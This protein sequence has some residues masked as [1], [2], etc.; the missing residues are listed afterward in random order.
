M[1][2]RQGD[3][4]TV[5]SKA[6]EAGGKVLEKY[7]AVFAAQLCKDR[8]PFEAI[9]VF[10]KHGAPANEANFNT[11][12]RLI[13]LAMNSRD[14]ISYKQWAE[15]RDMLFDLS[16]ALRRKGDETNA[17]EFSKYTIIIHYTALRSACDKVKGQMSEIGCKLAMSLLRHTEIIP[18]DRAFYEAGMACNQVGKESMAFVFLNRYLDLNEAIED[19]DLSGLDNVD[20]VGTDVPFE[21][22]LPEEHWLGEEK[23]EEVREYVLS[24]SVDQKVDQTLALDERGTYVGSLR[25]AKSG[26]MYEPCI[27]TGFPVLQNPVKFGGQTANKEDWNRFIMTT[28][29][30]HNADLQDVM[31][32]LA[33]WCGAS[34]SATYSFN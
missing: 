1:Y 10:V 18:A 27:V 9:A 22:P 33:S 25:D 23:R 4:N 2:V 17:D 6:E 3:W 12:R 28:K 19:E 32:F 11:Y 29:T 30:T 8:R 34:E 21:I 24:I 26:K 13:H 14:T 20:F 5:M 7:S 15:L 16:V 31:R